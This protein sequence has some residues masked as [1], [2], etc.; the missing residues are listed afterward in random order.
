MRWD[1]LIHHVYHR[2]FRLTANLRNC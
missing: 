1:V 2:P